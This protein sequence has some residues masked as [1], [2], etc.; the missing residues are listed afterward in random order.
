M[1]G[2]S[3]LPTLHPRRQS[4]INWLQCIIHLHH[5][6]LCSDPGWFREHRH[7][8]LTCTCFFFFWFIHL[9]C[10]IQQAK[11]LYGGLTCYLGY[12]DLTCYLG[13]SDLTCYLGYRGINYHFCQ[14]LQVLGCNL[15][16]CSGLHFITY[17]VGGLPRIWCGIR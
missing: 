16:N 10:T 13:Y 3:A 4:V 11:C 8:A 14:L 5:I 7:P 12:S 15:V 17:L 9:F 6:L 2:A 1:N